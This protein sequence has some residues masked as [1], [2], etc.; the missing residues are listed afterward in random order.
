MA[1]WRRSTTD[2]GGATSA[3]SE[4]AVSHETAALRIRTAF[5][6]ADLPIQQ[7]TKFDL[8]INLKT[9]KTLSLTVPQT[10]VAIADELLQ[11]Q[12]SHAAGPRRAAS[13]PPFAFVE[14]HPI[15]NER[16]AAAREIVPASVP[17]RCS[18]C[19]NSFARGQP[20]FPGLHA[21]PEQIV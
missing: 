5:E 17:G 2:K 8:A 16:Y 20:L 15:A 6:T 9:A 11:G 21:Q 14:V 19:R 3:D 12:G 4:G 10:L 13:R 1:I 7:P 18:G